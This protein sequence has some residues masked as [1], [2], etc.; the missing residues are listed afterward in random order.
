MDK[1]VERFLKYVSYDTGSDANSPTSPS[2]ARQYEFAKVLA[3]ELR[4]LGMSD[5]SIDEYAYV[6][7]TLP[8]N[9]AKAVPTIGFLAH[10]DVSADVPTAN[11][12]PLVVRDYDGGD[13]VINPEKG[14]VLSPKDFPDLKNYVGQDII[15]TD[16]TTLLGSD[17]KAGIAEIMTAMEYLI[18]HPEVKHGTVKVAF[19]PDEE[20]SRGTEHFDVAKFAADFAYTMDAGG[21]GSIVYE[22][23]NAA[24]VKVMVKGKNIHPGSA[25]NKMKNA[26][27]MAME[28]NAML[29][30]S[31]R[32]A[33]TE[34]YEGFYHLNNME[35]GVENALMKYIIRDHDGKVLAQRK[36]R[37]T[38]IAAFM[39]SVYGEGTIQ[40]EIKDQ[41]RNMAE[42]IESEINI[43]ELA[44]AAMRSLG[45][46]PRTQPMRGGTDGAQLSFMGLPCPNLFYGGHNVHGKMEYV[47]VGS[48]NKAK[49]VILKIIELNSNN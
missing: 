26:L 2:T 41:Y 10:M 21:L 40:L 13:I 1:M 43:V 35:G 23:F 11:I 27:L 44:R 38:A 22:T 20:I 30:A 45:I 25:K 49:D 19:T 47:P 4:D 29:P 34:G 42:V 28:F 5:V 17:D 31:E 9:I 37:M 6:Y 32:P 8:S 36:E 18:K 46:E 48:M 14:I 3:Q 39:N 12:K 33:H 7:A 16:G 15:T 24:S